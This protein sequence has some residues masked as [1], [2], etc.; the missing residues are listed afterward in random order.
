[1]RATLKEKLVWYRFRPK[2][3]VWTHA[4][5]KGKTQIRRMWEETWYGEDAKSFVSGL[6]I[7]LNLGIVKVHIRVEWWQ[8]HFRGRESIKVSNTR[9]YFRYIWKSIYVFLASPHSR[10]LRDW[11]RHVRQCDIRNQKKCIEVYKKSIES[12][13]NKKL[14]DLILKEKMSNTPN[15]SRILFLQNALD[16]GL[17]FEAFCNTGQILTKEDFLK[18]YVLPPRLESASTDIMEYFDG[19]YIQMFSDGLYGIYD[20]SGFMYMS[21][22]LNDIESILFKRFNNE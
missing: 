21:Y 2:I 8:I 6:F 22:K 10:Y 18:S 14:N 4:R 11:Y 5:T 19:S 20:E 15:K 1:M 13:M 12:K 16:K 3:S 9:K 17:S 7:L